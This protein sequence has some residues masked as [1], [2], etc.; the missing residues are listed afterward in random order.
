M[1]M[2]A[3]AESF[4]SVR[5][6]RVNVGAGVRTTEA[7]SRRPQADPASEAYEARHRAI[8]W[9]GNRAPLERV[10]AFLLAISRNNIHEGRDPSAI[11]ESLTCGFVADLVG[12]PIATVAWL[13]RVVEER[14]L[15]APDAHSGL[16]LKDLAGLEKL[17]RV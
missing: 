17:A 6:F 3:A 13:L 7:R 15:I 8:V 2:T 5:T 16:R 10:A 1:P 12:F 11:P 4:G 9:D 14:G